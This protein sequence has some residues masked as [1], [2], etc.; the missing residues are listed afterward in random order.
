[1]L[2]HK[3]SNILDACAIKIEN[4]EIRFRAA[5]EKL[6]IEMFFLVL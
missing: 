1:M 6:L 5:R 2:L 4:V 3:I